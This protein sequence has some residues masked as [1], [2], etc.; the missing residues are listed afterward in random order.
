MSLTGRVANFWHL[1]NR[2]QE[3]CPHCSR[4]WVILALLVNARA[5][6]KQD[7]FNSCSFGAAVTRYRP[8]SVAQ[9]VM[10][11]GGGPTPLAPPSG[12]YSF[13]RFLLGCAKPLLMCGFRRYA[14][15]FPKN[16]FKKNIICFLESTSTHPEEK[17]WF[18]VIT[19]TFHQMYCNIY[20]KA[21]TG[22]RVTQ[23]FIVGSQFPP[24]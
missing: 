6:F 18:S 5:L 10:V 4:I 12:V 14:I 11:S 13:P 23:V 20:D 1:H 8:Q 19:L 24:C 21:S 22:L 17:T 9:L 2:R 15:D 7:V 3:V 16:T